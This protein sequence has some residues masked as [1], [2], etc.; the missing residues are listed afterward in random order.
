[1][2]GNFEK[3]ALGLAYVALAVLVVIAGFD[4]TKASK[5]QAAAHASSNCTHCLSVENGGNSTEVSASSPR[6][7]YNEAVQAVVRMNRKIRD[8][9]AVR[10]PNAAHDP[11]HRM[12]SLLEDV[13]RLAEESEL[14]EAVR[15]SVAA[16]VEQLVD[17]FAAVDRRMHGKAG[18]CYH[19]VSPRIDDGLLTLIDSSSVRM[20]A[21]GQSVP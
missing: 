18:M 5:R 6:S 3:L 2:S 20:A 10:D 13:N 12:R 11:L 15:D 19:D 1:M 9:F 7:R 14:H 16:A 17:S 8:A 4:E 21:V